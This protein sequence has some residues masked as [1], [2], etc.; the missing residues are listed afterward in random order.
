MLFIPFHEK[1]EKVFSKET[2][3]TKKYVWFLLFFIFV[4]IGIAFAMKKEGLGLGP[5]KI[6]SLI[7]F[8]FFFTTP[9]FIFLETG[10]WSKR[11]NNVFLK[12][13]VNCS[14]SGYVI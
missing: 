11:I 3:W 5:W 6:G 10:E 2:K 12:L 1:F 14:Q 4:F 9:L 7:G 13:L 8:F